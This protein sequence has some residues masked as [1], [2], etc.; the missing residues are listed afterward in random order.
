MA[1]RSR[2]AGAVALTLAALALAHPA[3]AQAGCTTRLP[4]SYS[5]ESRFALSYR[6]VVPITVTSGARQIRNLRVKLYTFN[7]DLLGSV[8]RASLSG[9]AVL[10]LRLRFALQPGAYT[11]YAEGEPN[12]S[13]ACGPKH[14]SSVIRFSSCITSLPVS[15]P[16]PPGGYAEDYEGYLSFTLASRGALMRSLKVSVSNF[17]GELFGASSVRALFGSLTVNV[18]LRRAL[19][20]G[21][22]TIYVEGWISAQPRSCGPKS[23]EQVLTFN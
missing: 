8:S 14:S 21:G 19:T 9:S 10:R 6:R 20:P 5:L 18:P 7:G 1:G 13:S 11:I 22:Y 3:G 16:D 4:I 2:A 17:A 12:A 23:A 15:F